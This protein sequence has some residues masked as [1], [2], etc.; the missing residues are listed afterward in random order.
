MELCWFGRP[1]LFPRRM[2][3]AL[4][5]LPQTVEAGAML[6]QL[7]ITSNSTFRGFEL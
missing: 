7:Q 4:A 1:D 3:V 2:I 6:G 5:L